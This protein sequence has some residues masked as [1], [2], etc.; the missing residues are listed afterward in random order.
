MQSIDVR[1]DE[2]LSADSL[3]ERFVAAELKA[4]DHVRLSRTRAPSPFDAV[5]VLSLVFL[6]LGRLARAK[7]RNQALREKSESIVFTARLEEKLF[8]G[9]ATPADLEESIR[10][11][12]GIHVSQSGPAPNDDG[13]SGFALDGLAGAYGADEPDYSA[14]IIREPNPKYG[15]GHA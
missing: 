14:S 6:A 4:G 8:G 2:T 3:F 12:F 15:R 5:A 1:I 9:H 10:T 7:A 13:W 11:E